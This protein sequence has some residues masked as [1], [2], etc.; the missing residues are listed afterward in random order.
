MRTVT[1]PDGRRYS[2]ADTPVR[3][4]GYGPGPNR[5]NTIA[6]VSNEHA[7]ADRS[8]FQAHPDGALYRPSTFETVPAFKKGGTMS[9]VVRSVKNVTKG[10]SSV[11]V[12]VRNGRIRKRRITCIASDE[13]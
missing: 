6:V 11:Q 12:K 3:S 13:T 9:K 7:T 8:S 2:V 5:R 1:G 4:F 10:Y